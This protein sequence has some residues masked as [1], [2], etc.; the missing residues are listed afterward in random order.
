LNIITAI[1]GS[2]GLLSTLYLFFILARLSQKLGEV[3][4]M[5]PYHRG[6]YVGQIFLAMALAAYFLRASV[7]LTPQSFVPLFSDAL[8]YLVVYHLPLALAATA[9]LVITWHYWGWLLRER[10]D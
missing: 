9:A 1:L 6:F 7:Y 3:T 8:F 4:R 5:P 10:D 2:T